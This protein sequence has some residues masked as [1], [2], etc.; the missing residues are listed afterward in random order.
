[1]STYSLSYLDDLEPYVASLQTEFEKVENYINDIDASSLPRGSMDTQHFATNVVVGGFGTASLNTVVTADEVAGQ[2]YSNWPPMTSFGE[3]LEILEITG[4]NWDVTG[5][6]NIMHV[7]GN[8]NLSRVIGLKNEPA[9]RVL[10]AI[11]IERGGFWQIV[12]HTVRPFS[13]NDRRLSYTSTVRRSD[14]DM[15]V[16]TM[17]QEGTLPTNTFGDIVTGLRLYITIAGGNGT[18][19]AKVDA[20]NLSWKTLRTGALSG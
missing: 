19:T 4:L 18:G 14:I 8:A 5:D 1:M 12:P 16:S 17:F 6:Y 3:W 9:P 2:Q 10:F 13:V 7:S 11:G 15:S 20:A